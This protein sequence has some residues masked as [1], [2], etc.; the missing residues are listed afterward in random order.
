MDPL[1]AVYIE[2]LACSLHG[3]ELA[4]IQV[5]KNSKFNLMKHKYKLQISSSMML[6]WCPDA[7][8]LDLEW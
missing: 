8:L 3:V 2:P 7:D 5:I 1:L 6:S 4:D